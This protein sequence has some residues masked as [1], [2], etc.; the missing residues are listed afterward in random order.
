MQT[1]KGCE[2]DGK[3]LSSVNCLDLDLVKLTKISKYSEIGSLFVFL[4]CNHIFLEY[5]DF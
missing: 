1:S 4:Y 2:G 5:S 3:H